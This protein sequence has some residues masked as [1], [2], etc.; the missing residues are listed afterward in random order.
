MGPRYNLLPYSYVY[1]VLCSLLVTIFLFS[2]FFSYKFNR[3]LCHGAYWGMHNPA[4]MPRLL[5]ICIFLSLVPAYVHLNMYTHIPA[6]RSILL[7]YYAYTHLPA[8]SRTLMLAFKYTYISQY[9][10]RPLLYEPVVPLCFLLVFVYVCTCA[11]MYIRA[12]LW[13]PCIL[14]CVCVVCVFLLSYW[15]V[16]LCLVHCILCVLFHINKHFCFSKVGKKKRKKK[17]L[18]MNQCHGAYYSTHSPAHVHISAFQTHKLEL[19]IKINT[20]CIH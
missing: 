1:F 15:A 20:T 19:K 4:H 10:L 17:Y 2:F 3:H 13:I 6:H 16:Y 9:I 18:R 5:P 14:I 7:S 8:S 12:Y 11:H